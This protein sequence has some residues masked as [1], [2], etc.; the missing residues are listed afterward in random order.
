MIGYA[1]VINCCTFFI[2]SLI[3]DTCVIYKGKDCP[4]L[5]QQVGGNG[6]VSEW[7]LVA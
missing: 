6:R 7:G 5:V 1:K 4:F 2:Y 3:T